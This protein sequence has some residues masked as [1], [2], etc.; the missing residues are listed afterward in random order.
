MLQVCPLPLLLS[1][2]GSS[3]VDV[4]H[5][6]SPDSGHRE[7]STDS[8]STGGANTQS[9]VSWHSALAASMTYSHELV[10]G[11][12]EMTLSSPTRPVISSPQL[13]NTAPPSMLDASCNVQLDSTLHRPATKPTADICGIVLEN[14]AIQSSGRMIPV[15]S[16]SSL[17]TADQSL[18]HGNALFSV[19]E[20]SVTGGKDGMTVLDDLVT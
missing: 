10:G 9:D 17:S 5:D 20:D 8:L 4:E 13:V 14:I 6:T 3:R 19:N 11:L 7:L 1:P 18:S 16:R 15:D 2:S 12:R